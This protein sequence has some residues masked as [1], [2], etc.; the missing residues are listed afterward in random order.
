MK[1]IRKALPSLNQ[2]VSGE[3]RSLLSDPLLHS[4]IRTRVLLGAG[5]AYLMA[6]KIPFTA[7]LV[8]L[9][10]AVALGVAV[11]IPAWRRPA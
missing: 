11:S 6:A 2:E 3:F 1:K 8:A 9:A 10:A 4:A 5:I 7:S